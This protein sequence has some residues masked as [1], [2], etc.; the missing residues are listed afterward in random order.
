[1]DTI[2]INLLPQ[3]YAAAINNFKMNNPH[4]DVPIDE[5]GEMNFRDALNA[6]L[7][8]E[9]IHGYTDAILTFFTAMNPKEAEPLND[10]FHL[11]EAMRDHG[12]HFASNLA[13]AWQRA[14]SGNMRKLRREFNNLLET[15]RQYLP[16]PVQERYDIP[17]F[18][19]KK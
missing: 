16:K 14:D 9:G 5:A 3:T 18:L 2:N 17:E 10:E 4:H 11:V 8:W 7:R 19:R 13:A 12:G 6:Y 15:Y 1:M